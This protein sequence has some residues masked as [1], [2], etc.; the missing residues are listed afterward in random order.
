MLLCLLLDRKWH[1]YQGNLYALFL[2]E[3][4]EDALH[5]LKAEVGQDPAVLYKSLSEEETA[6]FDLFEKEADLMYAHKWQFSNVTAMELYRDP[7]YC[8]TAVVPA[9]TRYLGHVLNEE[10]NDNWFRYEHG[11]SLKTL[12]YTPIPEIGLSYIPVARDKKLKCNRT[13]QIDSKDFFLATGRFEGYQKITVPNDV[14]KRVY[15][16]HKPKGIIAACARACVWECGKNPLVTPQDVR[17]G[18]MEIRVNGVQVDAVEDFE[19]CYLF[20]KA[21]G[22]IHWHANEKGEYDI[23]VHITILGKRARFSSFIVW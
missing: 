17:N 7:T 12:H 1:T 8:H 5:E 14:E 4:L 19:N 22:E 16:P 11:L 10:R 18:N 13:L 20:Q 9:Q 23:E 15:G 6:D 2:M 21:N 3:V